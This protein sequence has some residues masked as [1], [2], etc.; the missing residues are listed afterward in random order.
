MIFAGSGAAL[1]TSS[2]GPSGGAFSAR[3]QAVLQQVTERFA[4]L[5]AAEVGGKRR[6]TGAA[7]GPVPELGLGTLLEGRSRADAARCFF[8]LLVLQ[9]GGHVRLSQA[10]P[11]QEIAIRPLGAEGGAEATPA[12]RRRPLAPVNAQN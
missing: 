8:E 6:R 1:E 2:G 4:A 7:A 12:T 10:A 3:T 5:A 9:N 11:F